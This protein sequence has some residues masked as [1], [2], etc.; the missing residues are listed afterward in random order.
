M[1]SIGDIEKRG[2]GRPKTDATP[3]LVRLYPDTLAA[4]DAFIA[5]QPEPRPTRPEA[6]RQ[7]LVEWLTAKGHL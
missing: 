5:K 7:A 6:I 1:T 3:I 2:R 4:I